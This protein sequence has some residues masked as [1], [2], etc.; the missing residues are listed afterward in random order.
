VIVYNMV[1]ALFVVVGG[2]IGAGAYVL[3]AWLLGR[4]DLAMSVAMGLGGIVA[5]AL[6]VVRRSRAEDD[7]EAWRF[8]SPRRGGHVMFVPVWVAGAAMA[9]F[10]ALRSFMR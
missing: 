2:A 10:G 9:I 3:V 1:G 5:A 6:D 4:D 7:P 8:F